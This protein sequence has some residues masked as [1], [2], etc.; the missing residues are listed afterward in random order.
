MVKK[1]EDIKKDLTNKQV[2]TQDAQKSVK[3]GCSCEDRRRPGRDGS[4]NWSGG[5]SGGW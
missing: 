1:L 5:W 3:G 2:V 4:G